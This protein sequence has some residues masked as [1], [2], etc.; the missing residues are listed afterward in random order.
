MK[1]RVARRI[2]AG[3]ESG[4][5]N[6]SLNTLRKAAMMVGRPIILSLGSIGEVVYYPK[7]QIVNC[8][9][10]GMPPHPVACR[11]ISEYRNDP[12]EPDDDEDYYDD[13]D[14]YDVEEAA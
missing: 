3:A 12:V 14:D 6:D 13:D 4:V 11:F 10:S 7:G 1:A 9:K 8:L 2:V 5:R